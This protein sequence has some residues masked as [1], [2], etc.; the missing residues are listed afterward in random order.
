MG[1]GTLEHATVQR[2]GREGNQIARAA[3]QTNPWRHES[4]AAPPVQGNS[5][6]LRP[7]QVVV[8]VEHKM[9]IPIC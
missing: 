5:T 7:Q 6:H 2:R 4:F 8:H 3:I 9:L 1:G